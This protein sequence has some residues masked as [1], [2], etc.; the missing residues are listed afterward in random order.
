[1]GLASE[2]K[3]LS[4]EIISSFKQRIKANDELV[5]EVQKTLEGFR[6]EH[7]K[8]TVVLRSGID[9]NE[10]IRLKEFKSMWND[11][12]NSKK[13]RLA[14]FNDM[15]D[16]IQKEIKKIASYTSNLLKEFGL[17]HTEMA[18]ALKETLSKGEKDRISDFNALWNDILNTKSERLANFKEMIL[19]IQKEIKE[20]NTY[21]T[22]LLK[23]FGLAHTE[24]AAALK[25]TLSKGEKDRISDFTALWSDI[26]NTKAERLENFKEM[27][28]N[29]QKDIS[30]I[31]AY[32]ANL[33]KEFNAT[34]NEL[35]KALKEKLSKDESERLEEFKVWFE[36]LQKYVS[37]LL[38]E[39]ANERNEMAANWEILTNAMADLRAGVLPSSPTK[40]VKTETPKSTEPT[41]APKEKVKAT[42]KVEEAPVK[43]EPAKKAPEA[44]VKAEPKPVV[45]MTLE[46]KI[47]NYVTKHPKGVKISEMEKPLGETR[48][49]LGYIAKNLLDAGKVQKVDNIYF[50][51]KK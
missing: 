42:E 21:T 45:P 20:I 47:L 19:N 51:L 29:I 50:P 15:M 38:A 22:N 6:K 43:A 25:E 36:E 32:T 37:D 30:G 1:M 10:K 48:M 16:N 31:E 4:E 17:A 28:V 12:L 5:T 9:K 39:C 11:I 27:M 49:K 14:L 34:H 44:P 7:Q 18:A 35:T 23:E 2:I 40:V 24:M 13:D 8:M 33:L 46:E 41:E 3:N 26:L